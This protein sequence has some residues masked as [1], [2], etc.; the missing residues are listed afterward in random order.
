MEM[1]SWKVLSVCTGATHMMSLNPFRLVQRMMAPVVEPSEG[2]T[3]RVH[4]LEEP[5][6]DATAPG[7]LDPT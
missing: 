4:L 3:E 7:D 6:E 2:I 5:D 1:E